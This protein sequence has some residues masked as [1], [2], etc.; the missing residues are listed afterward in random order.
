[1]LAH[2][3]AAVSPEAAWALADHFGGTQ[4]YVAKQPRP[5]S[6]LA[7]TLGLDV[8][9]AL[10]ALYGGELIDVPMAAFRGRARRN[11]EIR[12]Q[13]ADGVPMSTVARRFRMTV[14]NVRSI[15]NAQQQ[16]DERQRDLFG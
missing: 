5:D 9:M 6:R 2:V 12:R 4:V 16:R 14:R 7:R 1:M 13:L 8:A 3:A 11:A 10:A 15:K